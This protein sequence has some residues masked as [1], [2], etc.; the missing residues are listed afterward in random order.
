M[1]RQKKTS[2]RRAACLAVVV[3]IHAACGGP[4]PEAETKSEQIVPNI[5]AELLG[6]DPSWGNTEGPAAD[7]NNTLYFTSR[8]T[9]KG[10]ISWDEQQGFQQYA[11]VAA[12][13]GPGGLWI[14]GE[15]NIFLTATAER[16]ILKLTPDKKVTVVAED[17]EGD[18]ETSKGPNDIVVAG[19]GAIYFT[20]PNGYYGDSPPG[21]VYRISPD[22]ETAVF[23]DQVV[24]PNGIVLSADEKTLYVSHNTSKDES[25]IVQWPIQEDGAAGPMQE[26]ASIENCVAD[27]MAVNRDGNIWLTCYSYGTAYLVSPEGQIL[28]TI[29]TGQKALT[30][31][32]FGR[33][34]KNRTLYL[35]SSDMDRV[36]GYVYR[37]QVE[38]PGLR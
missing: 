31:C 28:K 16:Q 37:A 12:E 25:R 35:T 30:N 29:S 23:D 32:V 14:D 10:I 36:T 8:G 9:F 38:T 15:D 4:A 26:V 5:Q 19:G 11:E 1:N 27:G 17:F 7:S 3:A 33:G 34:E 20:A 2:A 24:G 18:P 13:A 22:G 21:T 6:S